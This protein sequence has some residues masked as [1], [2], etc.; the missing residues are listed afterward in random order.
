MDSQHI[1]SAKE[2]FSKRKVFRQKAF[3]LMGK[4]QD[5]LFEL[6]DAVIQIQHIQSFVG[7]SAPPLFGESGRVRMKPCKTVDPIEKGCYICICTN[8]A[9][10]HR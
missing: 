6:T 9:M 2:N 4:A 5:V 7:L 8:S 10:A 1:P 3:G